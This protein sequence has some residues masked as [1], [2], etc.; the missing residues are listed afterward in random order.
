MAAYLPTRPRHWRRMGS[1]AASS[2][3]AW[4]R[5]AATVAA[6][7]MDFPAI[8]GVLGAVFVIFKVFN[9]IFV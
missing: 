8:P 2:G 1:R 5:R 4:R 9:V 7:Q 6:V 3:D